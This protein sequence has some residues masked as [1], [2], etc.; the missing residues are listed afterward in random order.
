ML[1]NSYEFMLLFLPI[2]LAAWWWL[3]RWPSLRLTMLVAASYLFYGWWN[4]HFTALLAVSTLLD[5]IV[6]HAIER[7]E[8]K[9]KRFGFLMIS[10]VGNLGLLAYFKYTGFLA[11][12]VNDLL[13]AFRFGTTLPIPQIILPVGSSFYTFQTL[14][15]SIDLYRGQVKTARVFCISRLMYR[16]FPS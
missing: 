4:W 16:C 15:Y 6:G 10:L 14:T 1:F 11:T 12:A 8:N 7:S 9:R 3:G 5:W 2:C 13:N